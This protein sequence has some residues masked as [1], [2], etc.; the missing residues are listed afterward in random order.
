M[1][2]A[3]IFKLADDF[4]LIFRSIF[5]LKS[6]A[7]SNYYVNGRNRLILE[8]TEPLLI[9]WFDVNRILFILKHECFLLIYSF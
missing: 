5:F 7:N 6:V 1:V 2:F 3:Y 8:Q 4:I 9:V